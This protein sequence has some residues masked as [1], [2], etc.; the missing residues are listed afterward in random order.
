VDVDVFEGELNPGDTLLL[1]S[2]GLTGRVED[3]EIASI[4]HEYPVE[5]AARRLVALANDRGGN[6]NITVLLVSATQE[7]ATIRI[8]P[9][10]QP[11]RKISRTTIVIAGL[12]IVAMVLGGL[13]GARLFRRDEPTPMPTTTLPVVPTATLDPSVVATPTPEPTLAPAEADTPVGP[14]A[15][16]IPTIAATATPTATD[17]QTP[18]AT[19]TVT[20][21]PSLEPSDT[22]QPG[23]TGQAFLT[24]ISTVTVELPTE[25][26][27]T[28]PAPQP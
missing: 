9:E 19:P 2:D 12:A 27:T 10:S 14:T 11:T 20:V 21:E 4:V 26:P 7:A 5:E 1:C 28:P 13:A 15:T 24:A 22:A 18:T 6:D 3:H 25:E 23:G 8:R 16:L 17:T